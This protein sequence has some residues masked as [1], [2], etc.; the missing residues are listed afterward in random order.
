MEIILAIQNEFG[1]L[2][3]TI[4]P[5]ICPVFHLQRLSMLGAMNEFRATIPCPTWGEFRLYTDS[6]NLFQRVEWFVQVSLTRLWRSLLMVG[7]FANL[8]GLCRFRIGFRVRF[9]PTY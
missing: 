1:L 5:G 8:I 7:L 9:A 4:A 3:S 2:I 6:L